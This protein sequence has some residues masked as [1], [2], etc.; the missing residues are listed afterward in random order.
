MPLEEIT[1]RFP[2]PFMTKSISIAKQNNFVF[3]SIYSPIGSNVAGFNFGPEK[4]PILLVIGN[5]E[6]KRTK[7]TASDI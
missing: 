7:E 2:M 1:K 6:K 4:T 5:L 3:I